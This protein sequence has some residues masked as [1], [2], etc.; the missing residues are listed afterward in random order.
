M[1]SSSHL[2]LCEQNIEG[3]IECPV[4]FVKAESDL[5]LMV[6]TLKK[7]QY[8]LPKNVTLNITIPLQNVALRLMQNMTLRHTEINNARDNRIRPIS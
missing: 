7:K 4:I 3:F 8:N 6:T 1:R 5:E 2:C